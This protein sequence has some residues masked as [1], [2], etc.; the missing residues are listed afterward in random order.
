MNIR[1]TV[2]INPNIRIDK[3]VR[4]SFISFSKIFKSFIVSFF[5]LF[6]IRGLQFEYS[7]N[8][9]IRSA[10]IRIRV[11]APFQILRWTWNDNSD[12]NTHYSINPPHFYLSIWALPKNEHSLSF[13][14][15]LTRSPA[16]CISAI[17][18]ATTIIQFMNNEQTNRR[19]FTNSVLHSSCSFSRP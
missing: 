12:S 7:N 8:S 11:A 1:F 17:Q 19:D 2:R 10:I 15:F 6:S 9:I 18:W 14:Q 16:A 13:G 4:I 3:L 5:D